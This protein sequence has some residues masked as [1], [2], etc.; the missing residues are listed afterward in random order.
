MLLKLGS[1][2]EEVKQL[3]VKLNKLG[4]K[5]GVPNAEF[6]ANTQNAVCR[7]QKANGLV[8]DGIVGEG[9]MGV[10]DKAI[11]KLPKPKPQVVHKKLCDMNEKVFAGV[12]AKVVA[13]GKE[14]RQIVKDKYNIDIIFTMGY[15]S[16]AEQNN[17]YASGRTRKGRIVTN[18]KGGQSYHN[19]GLALDFVPIVNGKADWNDIELFKKVAQEAV[20][21][22]FESGANFTS[23]KDYPHIQLTFGLSINELLHGVKIPK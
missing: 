22:G 19:Y 13:K 1:K 2:G 14:L 3:Q 6:D 12:H 10:I 15:R 4:Y 5:V 16:I 8:T 20:K 17:L 18:A 21:L 7:L 9:T 11:A 23:I